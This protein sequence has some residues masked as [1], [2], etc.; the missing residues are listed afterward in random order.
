VLACH[1]GRDNAYD[2][3]NYLTFMALEG[4]HWSEI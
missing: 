3:I 2:Q 4:L 1:S